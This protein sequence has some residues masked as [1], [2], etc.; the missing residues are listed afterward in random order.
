[1]TLPINYTIIEQKQNTCVKLKSFLITVAF[2]FF[3]ITPN[4]LCF[5]YFSATE[6]LQLIFKSPV[7]AR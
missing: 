1:M 5:R 3:I 6:G 4:I 2:D 7:Q